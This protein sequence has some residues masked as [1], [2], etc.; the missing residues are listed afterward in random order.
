LDLGRVHEFIA[1]S[2]LERTE[3]PH[4]DNPKRR[5][6]HYAVRHSERLPPATPYLEVFTRLTKLSAAPSL[7]GI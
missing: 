5:V 3:M 6:R 1:L 2:V 4:P 7:S